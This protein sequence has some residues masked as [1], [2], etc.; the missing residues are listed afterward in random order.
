MDRKEKT[1]K[2]LFETGFLIMVANVVVGIEIYQAIIHHWKI[3]VGGEWFFQA[4][5]RS[6]EPRFLMQLDQRNLYIY[7]LSV[8]FSFMGN[9]EELVLLFHLILKLAGIGLFYLGAKRTGSLLTSLLFAVL[10][11]V[12]SLGFYPIVED[13]SMH[14]VWFLAGA[15]F[16]LCTALFYELP[17]KNVLWLLLGAGIGFFSYMDL[18]AAGLFVT[19]FCF[20]LFARKEGWK[21]KL[22]HGTLFAA[23]A[24]LSFL[25]TFYLWNGYH[26]TPDLLMQWGRKKTDL[27]SSPADRAR[28]IALAVLFALSIL[29]QILK[30]Y[31]SPKLAEEETQPL[32][33]KVSQAVF[34]MTEELHV[35]TEKEAF[36]QTDEANTKPQTG[37][38]RL[39]KNPLPLPKKHVKKELNYAFDPTAEQMHYDLNNY[40][41]DDDYDLK[42]N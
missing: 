6:A 41:L 16:W 13:S 12:F 42:D 21:E 2:I 3:A 27:F 37:H 22:L 19:M 38:V 29:L 39:L 36:S 30:E 17:W 20:L 18:F 10:S 40:R 1:G 8:L 25:G 4:F 26:L 9:H 35:K 23:A 34:P 14:L 24:C 7:V 11:A 28:Y 15:L 31:R 32:E 5:I 33:R